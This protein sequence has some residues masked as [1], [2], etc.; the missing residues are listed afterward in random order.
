V[1]NADTTCCRN[2]NARRDR[3]RAQRYSIVSFAVYSSRRKRLSSHACV[4]VREC[5]FNRSLTARPHTFGAFGKPAG[6]SV[7][8]CRQNDNVLVTLRRR[9][10]SVTRRCGSRFARGRR[11][12]ELYGENGANGRQRRMEK[13]AA[14]L[15]V[16]AKGVLLC[17]YTSGKSSVWCGKTGR[18]STVTTRVFAVVLFRLVRDRI[19]FG[20]SCSTTT[21]TQCMASRTKRRNL[22]ARRRPP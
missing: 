5:I 9:V 18:L 17:P 13:K 15:L 12:A 1:S 16:E 11:P 8:R 19:S 14:E 7:V 21:V 10:R 22:H 3:T 20:L 4:R 2:Y 6:G